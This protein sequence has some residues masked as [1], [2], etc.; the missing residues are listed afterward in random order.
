MFVTVR[1]GGTRGE[2]WLQ[3]ALGARRWPHGEGGTWHLDAQQHPKAREQG[4]R[5]LPEHISTLC[6]SYLL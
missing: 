1:Y 5:A 2:H 3:A 6:S 4:S